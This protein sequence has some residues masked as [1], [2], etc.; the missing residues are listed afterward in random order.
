M[1]LTIP[2]S[3]ERVFAVLSDGWAYASWVVGASHIRD[4][5]QGF[6]TPGT[7]IHHSVGGWPLMIK[8][9]SVV[10]ECEPN[11]R[12]VLKVKVWPLFGGIVKVELEP[13]GDGGTLAAMSEELVDG[14]G[15]LLPE[16][17]IAPALNARNRESLKRLADRAVHDGR[18]TMG[19]ARAT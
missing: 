10:L 11:Q 13:H 9:E 6:P 7:K 15:K 18:Y 5:D 12:I 16:P 1:R 19:G 8:D 14:P 3:P 4:V 17:L 2:A